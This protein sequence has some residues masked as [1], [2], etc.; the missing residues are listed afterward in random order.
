MASKRKAKFRKGQVVRCY[1]VPERGEHNFFLG[2]GC[3]QQVT[4]GTSTS[5][6]FFYTIDG[7]AYRESRLRPLTAREKGGA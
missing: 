6:A 1:G 2:Y 4:R 5:K 7:D 3:I